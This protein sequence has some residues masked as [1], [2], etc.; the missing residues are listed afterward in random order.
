[1]K[2]AIILNRKNGN[3]LWLDAIASGMKNVRIV[4]EVFE[5]ALPPKFTEVKC[6]MIFEIKMGETF[7]R[8][9]GMVTGQHTADIPAVL[10]YSSIASSDTIINDMRVLSCD[11]Q[12]ECL[13]YCEK[14]WYRSGSEFIS[15]EGRMMI[16]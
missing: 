6:R 5:G 15:D 7:R 4:L 2:E 3:T 9:V 11:I 10:A 13:C 1:M 12:N 14:I 16:I 8:K